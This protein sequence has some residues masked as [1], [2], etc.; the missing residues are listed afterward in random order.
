MRRACLW[1]LLLAAP[2][3]ADAPKLTLP[4][5]A[6][7][8]VGD[9]IRVAADTAGKQVQW[10]S[11]DAGLKVFPPELLKDS[12][13]AVVWANAAGRYRLLAYTGVGDEV[14]LP[15]VCTVVVGTPAPVPPDPGPGPKPPDP[16]QPVAGLRVLVVYESADLGKMPRGQLDVIYGKAV[17]DY[18]S[19]KT[20][21]TADGGKRGWYI[22]DQNTDF[23]GES[24]VWQDI[25]K[26]PRAAL[27]WLVLSDGGGK[28]VWEGPLPADPTAMLARLKLYGG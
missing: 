15:A 3:R 10:V 25:L 11:M 20:T 6:T 23:S 16:P 12:K 19:T 2:L 28:V 9:P 21:P 14:S 8:D 22:A 17:R 7:G 24:K 1:L 18:L 4:K 13:T 27:P 5:E 26:R